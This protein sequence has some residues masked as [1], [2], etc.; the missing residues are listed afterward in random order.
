MSDPPAQPPPSGGITGLLDRA[1][2]FAAGGPWKAVFIIALIIVGGGGY[3]VYEKRN[4]LLESWLTPSTPQLVETA[5]IVLEIEKLIAE[6]DIDLVQIWKVVGSNQQ[7]VA[8]R[9]KDG[10]R[11]VI[12][13]PRILPIMDRESDPKVVASVLAGYPWCLDLTT[14]GTPLARRLADRNYNRGCAVAIPPDGGQVLGVMYLVWHDA[15]DESAENV[16]KGAA[17]EVARNLATH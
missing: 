2:A 8:A 11:P 5:D 4:E 7:F 16:A 6:N 17:R 10:E 13:E 3:I 15:R 9:R 1:L 12:P 14:A